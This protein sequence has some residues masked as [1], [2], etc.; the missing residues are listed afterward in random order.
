MLGILNAAI[1][2]GGGKKKKK[3]VGK[4]GFKENECL[5]RNKLGK[6]AP[7]GRPIFALIRR[8][9]FAMNRRPILALNSH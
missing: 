6:C 3:L 9:I 5:K 7:N 8:P 2:G 4:Y 1:K